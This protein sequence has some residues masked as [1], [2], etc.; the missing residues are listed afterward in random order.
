VYLVASSVFFA[1]S[2]FAS[3]WGRRQGVDTGNFGSPAVK[4]AAVAVVSFGHGTGGTSIA[5]GGRT[6]DGS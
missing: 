4:E 5:T 3:L 6:F 2:F 1:S